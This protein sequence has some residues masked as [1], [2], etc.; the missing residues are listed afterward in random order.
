VLRVIASGKSNAEVARTLVIA[1][2]MVNPLT[3][4]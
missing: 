1:L 3:N 2:S 4:S